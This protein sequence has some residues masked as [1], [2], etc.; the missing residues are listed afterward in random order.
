MF[1]SQYIH[2]SGAAHRI[3]STAA[4]DGPNTLSFAPIRARNARPRA[5][6]CASG[7]TK[8]TVAGSRSTMRVKRGRMGGGVTGA[9]GRCQAPSGWPRAPARGTLASGARKGEKMRLVGTLV[10]L[11]ALAFAA[12]FL[13]F[14]LTEPVNSG[15]TR[16]MNKLVPWAVWQAVA[17]ALA[18]AAFA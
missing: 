16:G 14:Y 10:A 1:G 13:H 15:F 7:P 18:V 4:G 11:W 9:P 3:A 12:S 2:C 17:L 8:G 6:S 5:R